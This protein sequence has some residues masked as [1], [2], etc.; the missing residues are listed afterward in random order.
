M[1]ASS[2]TIIFSPYHVGS[3]D[4]RVGN[5]PHRIRSLGIVKVLENLGVTINF[6]E[7]P[8]MDSFE[9]EI[10]R[11]FE[12]LRRTS[13][14]V[15]KA[16]A[17]NSFPLILSGNCMASAAAACGLRIKDLRFVYLTLTMI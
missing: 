7:I 12:L 3:L 13:N 15:S 14:A 10:S 16:V 4:H 8:H 9:G 5:G 2:I 11:S 1:P 17:S 6:D